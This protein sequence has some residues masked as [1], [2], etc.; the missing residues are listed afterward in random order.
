M[1]FFWWSILVLLIV[2]VVFFGNHQRLKKQYEKKQRMDKE[3]FKNVLD[4]L[5]QHLTLAQ[6]K[7]K[8]TLDS[9]IPL[10]TRIK[11]STNF[12]F[13]QNHDVKILRNGEEKYPAL[14]AAL[15]EAQ[16]HIH[17]LYYTIQTDGIGRDLCDLLMQKAKEGVQVRV[18]VDGVGSRQLTKEP[19]L[20][21]KL[22]EA[23]VELNIFA[24]PKLSFL[25]H[26]NF[27]NHRKI[28]VIDG[29]VGFTG[30]LNIGDE[31]LHK[32]PSKGYW[33][34]LHLR[35]EGEAVLLLQRIFATDWYY[36]TNQKLNE[37]DAY[38][39]TYSSREL[40]QKNSEVALA[41][42]VPSGPDM[43]QHIIDDIY[44]EMVYTA[45]EKVWFATPYFI[46]N[47]QL[48]SALKEAAQKGI[49]VR[50]LVPNKTDNPIVQAASYHFYQPL[51]QAGV[52]IYRYQ[53][54][55]YHAK[56]ALVDQH[57]AKIGSANMDRR[58]F[59]YSFETGIFVYEPKTCQE[60]QL[61]FEQDFQD[62]ILMQPSLLKRRTF[63]QKAATQLSLLLVP[64]L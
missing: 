28:A 48:L 21:H 53:K 38:F 15:K 52:K 44:K 57:V 60:L 22:E 47:Q 46:P 12:P 16:H 51:L 27:R 59:Y 2:L 34:D 55:F 32:D 31:Y 63:L 64:W 35:I 7:E 42:V 62:S 25:W 45:Q 49:D 54:G 18:I 61:L 10:L 3:L 24:P 1:T 50:L 23:G 6:V 19:H 17:L 33:R 43:G 13:T 8:F 36:V 29:K 5:H 30:G 26:L 4:H 20:Q 40:Q 58:S 41:Q 14:F 56:I 9:S 37:N 11:E 39:P